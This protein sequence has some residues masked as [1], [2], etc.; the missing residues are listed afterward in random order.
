MASSALGLVSGSDVYKRKISCCSANVRSV[1]TMPISTSMRAT[2][3]FHVNREKATCCRRLIRGSTGFAGA[4]EWADHHPLLA[5]RA[6]QPDRGCGK[7][8]PRS[9]GGRSKISDG[10]RYFRPGALVHPLKAEGG[11]PLVAYT[12]ENSGLS[13][14]QGR[15]RSNLDRPC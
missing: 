1:H 9:A 10:V 5:R 6:V 13:A 12:L 4:Q 2:I 3:S 14:F 7:C 8:L 11:G 15:L